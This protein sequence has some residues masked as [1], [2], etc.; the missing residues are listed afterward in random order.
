MSTTI[1]APFPTTKVT[2]I[3]PSVKL[4][5]TR[6]PESTITVKRTM[7]GGTK[8]YVKTS[9]RVTLT[10]PFQV[11]RQ[12]ELEIN[13]FLKIYQGA[14]WKVTLF[15]GSEWQANLVG[16]PVRRRAID[17]IGGQKTDLTGEE[18]IELTMTVSATR[19]S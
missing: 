7:L 16:E 1:E 8:T 17:R 11:T 5:N 14:P 2:M 9:D 4:D 13:A 19:I 3:L 18:I 10:L 15:D 6:T 12:K